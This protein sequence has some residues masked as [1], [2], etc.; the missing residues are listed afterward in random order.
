MSAKGDRKVAR[1]LN[2]ET[3]SLLGQLQER[4]KATLEELRQEEETQPPRS[5]SEV[6]RGKPEDSE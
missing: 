5:L 1:R 3:L 6:Y 4:L 2:Q